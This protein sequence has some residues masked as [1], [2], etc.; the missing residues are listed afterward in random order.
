MGLRLGDTE[1]DGVGVALTGGLWATDEQHG[2]ELQLGALANQVNGAVRRVAG[3]RNH[4][5]VGALRGDLRLGDAGRVDAATNHLDGLVQ[6]RQR[7]W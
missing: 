7:R 3:K 1:G 6:V 4:D 2:P 5:G